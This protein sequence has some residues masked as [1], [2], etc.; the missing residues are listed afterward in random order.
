MVGFLSGF[1]LKDGEFG[2]LLGGIGCLEGL[3]S[4]ETIYLHHKHA[5]FF[6]LE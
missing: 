3:E 6:T 2:V 1:H 4:G 5:R